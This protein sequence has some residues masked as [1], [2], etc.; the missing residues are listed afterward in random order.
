MNKRIKTNTALIMGSAIIWAAVIV[1]S[2]YALR[3]TGCYEK[4]QNILVGGVIAHII[5]IW[6]SMSFQNKKKKKE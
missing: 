3:G 4:I 6:G 2:A 1:G 5:L